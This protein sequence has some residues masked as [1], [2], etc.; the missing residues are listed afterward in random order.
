MEDVVAFIAKEDLKAVQVEV[1][2][3]YQRFTRLTQ[4]RTIRDTNKAE[5]GTAR[6]NT[7]VK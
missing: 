7:Q 2:Q 1:D 4:N 5:G 6:V 3:T